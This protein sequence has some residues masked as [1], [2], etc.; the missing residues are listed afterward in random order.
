MTKSSVGGQE[1]D[2]DEGE[3]EAGAE[4]RADDAPAPLEDQLHDVP[5][6]QEHEQ[7]QQDERELEQPEDDDVGQAA[8]GAAHRRRP[9]HHD[10]EEHG[11]QTG[12]QNDPPLAPAAAPARSRVILRGRRLRPLPHGN[13]GMIGVDV[14]EGKAGPAI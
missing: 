1:R 10:D 3:D 7:D 4:M 2:R 14:R 6:D 11:R 8:R 12:G 5:A 9:R 13:C